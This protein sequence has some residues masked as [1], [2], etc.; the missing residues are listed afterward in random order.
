MTY[1]YKI[2]TIG[3][4][5]KRFKI[6]RLY[7]SEADRKKEDLARSR[8]LNRLGLPEVFPLLI[9][10]TLPIFYSFQ[11]QELNDDILKEL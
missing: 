6:L 2:I 11:Q 10:K 5:E 3:H 9:F 1:F 4:G 7:N 8:S